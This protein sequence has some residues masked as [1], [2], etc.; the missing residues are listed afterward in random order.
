MTRWTPFVLLAS[1]LMAACGDSP[2]APDD[3]A[4]T[5]ILSPTVFE[6]TLDVKGER[7]YSFSV[8]QSGSLTAH[9]ASLTL[10][11][12]REVLAV[13]VR[14]GVGVPRG[15]GCAVTEF[16]DASPA[17]VTQLTTTLPAGIYC[18]NIS[19]IGALPEAAVFSIRF[20]HS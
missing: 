10:V 7:F 2:T 4:T 19:D 5:T 3:T 9:L 16:V 6:G 11:G 18:M 8:A 15:E 13:P 20:L 17:L 14:L 12:H 1:L